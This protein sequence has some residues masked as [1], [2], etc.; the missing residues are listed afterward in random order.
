MENLK[1]KVEDIEFMEPELFEVIVNAYS[2]SQHL[3]RNDRIGAAT[4][5]IKMFCKHEIFEIK[6]AK[7]IRFEDAGKYFGMCLQQQKNFFELIH[8]FCEV[9]STPAIEVP[10]PST[11][12][13]GSLLSSFEVNAKVTLT[14]LSY[15]KNLPIPD[16]LLL[17]NTSRRRRELR[18][19]IATADYL[20]GND[21]LKEDQKAAALVV[22]EDLIRYARAQP[23]NSHVQGWIKLKVKTESFTVAA[24]AL[25]LGFPCTATKLVHGHEKLHEVYYFY[26]GVH[27]HTQGGLLFEELTKRRV[28]EGQKEWL[29]TISVT[30]DHCLPVAKKFKASH[31]Q[32]RKPDTEKLSDPSQDPLLATGMLTINENREEFLE[33][34][35]EELV[36]KE[37]AKTERNVLIKCYGLFAFKGQLVSL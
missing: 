36:T 4:H 6:D 30:T 34:Y 29:R 32:A 22:F 1:E 15:A 24:K 13:V 20:Y 37:R 31:S 28:M 7:L 23:E 2:T 18:E 14:Y 21:E 12:S 27:T 5:T 10:S 19:R 17:F 8:K 26:E 35:F 9:M 33:L 16:I 3:T 25:V 11:S